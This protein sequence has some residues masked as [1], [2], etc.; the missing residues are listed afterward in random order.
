[1]AITP[2]QRERLDRLM[3]DRRLEL[4]ITWRDVAARAGRSYEALRL[5]R[6]GAGGINELTAVQFSR[7][8]EW[9][10][11]SILDILAGGNPEPEE[12]GPDTRP[13]IVRD[14]WDDENIR[15]LWSLTVSESQRL[16]LVED[17][18]AAQPG[19]ENNGAAV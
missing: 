16:S 14:N 2:E 8:L 6:S 1:M 4:G 18:L 3:N 9:K 15:K 13:Q 7:A 19:R 17:F 10:S 12:S 11:R 5:L